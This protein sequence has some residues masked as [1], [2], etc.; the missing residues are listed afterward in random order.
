MNLKS[1]LCLI[2]QLLPLLS[3]GLLGN[4]IPALAENQT[5]KL[6]GTLFD[7]VANEQN[8]GNFVGSFSYSND[9]ED[10]SENPTLSSFA[11]NDWEINFDNVSRFGTFQVTP[12]NSRATI[13]RGSFF[14][15]ANDELII[16][17]SGV[18]LPNRSNS[19]QLEVAFADLQATSIAEPPDV[20]D[21]GDFQFGYLLEDLE[22]SPE[23]SV[24]SASLEN[25]ESVSEPTTI[26][27][28]ESTTTSVPESTTILGL[29]V[30]LGSGV[31]LKKAK[32]IG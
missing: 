14:P 1:K 19:S 2:I 30:A 21:F 32:N 16:I 26:S 25:S 5:L 13:R 8:G 7:N 3:T 27:V 22:E 4:P 18:F 28:P 11:L 31:L 24:T 15:G 29:A 23:Y 6:S 10:T 17:F 9:A 20:S 12:N